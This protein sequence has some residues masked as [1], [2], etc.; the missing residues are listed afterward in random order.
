METILTNL[1]HV[2]IATSSLRLS[3][4]LTAVCRL[5]LLTV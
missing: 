3:T 2:A 5:L 4:L 1:Y